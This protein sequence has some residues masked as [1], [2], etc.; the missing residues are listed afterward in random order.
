MKLDTIFLFHRV[1]GDDHK[2]DYEEKWL[3]MADG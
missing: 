1:D 3:L 2:Q